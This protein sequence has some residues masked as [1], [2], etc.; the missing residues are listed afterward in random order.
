MAESHVVHLACHCQAHVLR[1]TLPSEPEPFTNNGVCDCSHCIKRK[2]VWGSAPP[3][4]RFEIIRGVGKD[5]VELQEYRF[6]SKSFAHH[7]CATC[8][9][10]MPGGSFDSD[11]E[12]MYNM[13]A[14]RDPHFDLWQHPLTLYSG[15]ERTPPYSHPSLSDLPGAE[16][17][18]ATR[19]TSERTEVLVGACHCQA[20]K[21]AVLSTPLTETRANDCACSICLGVSGALAVAPW[22]SANARQNGA[23]WIYPARQDTF[24]SP[25]LPASP[26]KPLDSLVTEYTFGEGL[27][28]HYFCKH[29]GCALYEFRAGSATD[30]C[31]G[32]LG[33]NI[34]LL[35]DIDEHLDDLH[36]LGWKACDRMAD[37]D[38]KHRTKLNGLKRSVDDRELP[39]LYELK[40]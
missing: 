5:G 30:E 28:K 35:N 32:S 15:A 39:P 37:Y 22:L 8:G 36:A 16:D 18:L 29:C 10:L 2:V 24:W 12:T 7:F 4:S 31:E 27:N 19:K 33:L 13:R 6:G 25:S 3:G 34:A 14:I 23:T 17:Y 11:K 40:V 38:F 21:F 26:W 20:I 9:T 1:L